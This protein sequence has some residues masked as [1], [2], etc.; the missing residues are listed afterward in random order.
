MLCS[1]TRNSLWLFLTFLAS[2]APAVS[3]QID[4]ELFYQD[5]HYREFNQSGDRLLTEY[6]HIPGGRLGFS[7]FPSAQLSL[8]TEAQ[9]SH[10]EVIYDGRSSN[11]RPFHSHTEQT[12]TFYRLGARFYANAE[13]NLWSTLAWDNHQWDRKIKGNQGVNG[14][15]EYYRWQQVSMGLGGRWQLKEL[16]FAHEWMWHKQTQ[17]ELTVDLTDFGYGKPKLTQ[18]PQGGISFSN[19]VRWNLSKRLQT[20]INYRF[21]RWHFGES[22]VVLAS[23]NNNIIGISEPDSTSQMHY[24]GIGLSHQFGL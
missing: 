7:I 22:D 23:G 9:K 2:T 11:G 20:F 5:F 18:K 17:A 14:L 1:S 16:I 12:Q 15:D 21:S 10:G 4:V 3:L 13:H 6:G 24:L 19:S 8:F